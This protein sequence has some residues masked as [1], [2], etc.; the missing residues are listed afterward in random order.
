MDQAGTVTRQQV[1]FAIDATA[2]LVVEDLAGEM[3]RD[4]SKLL[5]EFLASNTGALLYKEESKLWCAGPAYIEDL[6]RQE[7]A[8]P[9]TQ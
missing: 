8:K 9:G 7:I 1:E 6:Y 2:A 5:A 4:P 3:H